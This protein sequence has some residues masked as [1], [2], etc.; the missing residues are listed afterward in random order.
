MNTGRLI[1]VFLRTHGHV[2]SFSELPS[3]AR[4]LFADSASAKTE[5]FYTTRDRHFFE[6]FETQNPTASYR[7]RIAFLQDR[8]RI[9]TLLSARGGAGDIWE[10][11]ALPTETLGQFA[12]RSLS[13]RSS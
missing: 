8:G 9:L 11:L 7:G 6:F 5:V 12:L 3:G 2:C 4:A 13:G 10:S 1:A